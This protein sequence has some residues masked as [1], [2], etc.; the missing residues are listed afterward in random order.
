M[1]SRAPPLRSAACAYLSMTRTG[2]SRS[3]STRRVAPSPTPSSG[4]ACR[5]CRSYGRPCG[6]WIGSIPSAGGGGCRGI[7]SRHMSRGARAPCAASD[8]VSCRSLRQLVAIPQSSFGLNECSRGGLGVDFTGSMGCAERRRNGMGGT[9]ECMHIASAVH[10]GDASW[11]QPPMTVARVAGAA[12][13]VGRRESRSRRTHENL[14]AD[15]SRDASRT[16][17]RAPAGDENPSCDRVRQR[18][19][20]CAAATVPTRPAVSRIFG[21]C[22]ACQPRG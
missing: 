17:K 6:R 14:R 3:A 2:T 4:A 9:A 16:A 21:I 12:T 20:S 22:L 18:R 10:D 1:H 11:S 7:P 15:A 5:A 8:E 19:F 13:F